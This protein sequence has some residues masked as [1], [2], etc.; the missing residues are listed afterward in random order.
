M[1]YTVL[2][3]LIL[4]VAVCCIEE[5]EQHLQNIYCALVRNHVRQAK[6]EERGWLS[7]RGINYTMSI[8]TLENYEL[9]N[10]VFDELYRL[11]IKWHTYD[12]SRVMQ[13][14]YPVMIHQPSGS[15]EFEKLEKYAVDCRV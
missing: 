2:F 3:F 15:K 13:S 14:L 9:R 7:P 11:G 8:D 4:V 1:K 10:G 12:N 6:A 5:K